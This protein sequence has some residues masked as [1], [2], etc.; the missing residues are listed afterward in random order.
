M[1]SVTVYFIRHGSTPQNEKSDAFC[2][3]TDPSL[4]LRG[5]KQVKDIARRIKGKIKVNHILT[6]P[7][8]RTV[9][10]A[11]ILSHELS[12]PYFLKPDLREIDFG[13]WEGLTKAE[14]EDRYKEL[15]PNWKAN[16][17]QVIPPGSEYPHDLAKRAVRLK[18]EI[19]DGDEPVMLVSHR[20]FLRIALCEWLS[21]PIG[22]YRRSFDIHNGVLGCIRISPD[23][24]NLLLLNWHPDNLNFLSS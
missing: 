18:G 3:S 5:I 17:A 4:S 13:Q 2:G 15:F 11:K 8:K 23:E 10:S 9:E 24:A 20:T 7:M 16:P 21:I 19:L 6:S 12:T 14:I 22:N 1:K